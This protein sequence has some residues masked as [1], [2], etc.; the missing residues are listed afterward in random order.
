MLSGG[1]RSQSTENPPDTEQRTITISSL[2]MTPVEL[3]YVP[4]LLNETFNTALW[5]SGE[6]RFFISEEV[7][8]RYFSYRPCQKPIDRVVTA[9][10]T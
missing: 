10:V 1:D 6:E 3:P 5:D 4:I 7:Y 9:Q 2:R 8:R